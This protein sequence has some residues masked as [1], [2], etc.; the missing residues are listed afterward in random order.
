M[1]YIFSTLSNL[2]GQTAFASLT[3]GNVVMI[4]VA[5]GFLYLAIQKGYE[6]LLFGADFVRYA[7]GKYL[8]AYHGRGR[9]VKLLLQTG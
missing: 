9:T 5:C 3:V 4:A 1:D 8:S 7:S 2:M 6:P